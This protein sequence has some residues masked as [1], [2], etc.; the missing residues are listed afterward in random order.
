[1][2][3]QQQQLAERMVLE[4]EETIKAMLDRCAGPGWTYDQ[5]AHRLTRIE[6]GGY[7]NYQWD[8]HIVLT[9][10]PVQFGRGNTGGQPMI[11]ASR[12]LTHYQ[13]IP[14]SAAIN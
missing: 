4:E 7:E 3:A 14:A 12:E 9:L 13:T 5:I 6:V 11:S 10:G 2:K 1:M 8:G